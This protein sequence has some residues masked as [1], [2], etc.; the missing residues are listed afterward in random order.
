MAEVYCNTY[1]VDEDGIS[2][3]EKFSND[4]SGS[5]PKWDP[6]ARLGIFLD[7]SS[8]HVGN[9]HLVFNPQAGHV[10][11]QYHV[12]FDDTFLIVS[13]LRAGTVPALW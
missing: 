13:H 2:P 5:V 3:E 11:P 10:S 4:K 6:R 8:V 7:P 9:V 1:D 12:V